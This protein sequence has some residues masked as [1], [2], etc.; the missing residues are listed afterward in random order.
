MRKFWKKALSFV[1]AGSMVFSMAACG[2]K[3]DKGTD[4]NNSTSTGTNST[5]STDTGSSNS[6]GSGSTS[7]NKKGEEPI[8][9]T[10]YSQLANFSGEQV[11]WFAKVLLDKFNV[12]LMI[13]PDTDG[14]F[15]TRMESGNLG[16]IVVFGSTGSDYKRA[17]EADML[18]DWEEDGLLDEYGPYIKENMAQAL[19][20]NR[21]L[22]PEKN[23]IYGFGHG[24]AP[25][26]DSFEEFFYTWDIRW[27]LYKQLGYPVVKNLDDLVTLLKDMKELCPTDDNGKETY[28]VSIWPDWDGNM[29][30]YVKSMATAYYGYDELHLGLYDSDTGTFYGALDENGPYLE[31]LKFF[32]TL[33]REDLLDPNSMTQTYDE[34]ISKVQSGGVFF[35]IF[36]YA[37]NLAYNT[38]AHLAENKYMTTLLPEE[39]SPITYGMS[40]FGGNR[41]WAI[42][43]NSQYPEL[44]MEIINWMCTPEGKMVSE[45]GPQG[46]IWDYDAEGYTYFTEF[47]KKC[48]T[49]SETM[50]EGE[51]AGFN[52]GDGRQQ[53]NNI[54]WSQ[55]AENP[56]SNGETYNQQTWK[57]NVSQASCDMEQDW[58]DFTGAVTPMEY[59]KTKNFKVAPATTYSDSVRSDELE[60]VWNQVTACIVNGSWNCIYA[61]SDG[62]YNMHLNKMLNDAKAYGYE[63]CIEWCLSEAAR[64]HEL[65]EEVRK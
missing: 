36:N 32:N 44:C 46:L 10:V 30:M 19:E 53:I 48:V 24:V 20:A 62:E 25:S 37:G 2:G 33:Y 5:A 41:V 42:G 4:S 65:E 47:G 60:V 21:G 64:R 1:L 15:D 9:L 7:T 12:K 29:V 52:Y 57:S 16:D 45:Y 56:D 51:Y 54:T 17:V 11:G 58:R 26:S 40:V 23:K 18:F 39:A 14:V 50:M 49:D 34:M 38:E 55:N 3:E 43:A 13:I 63:D 22:T 59:L 27:D 31:M 35:S 6:S 8:E 61:K 28:P